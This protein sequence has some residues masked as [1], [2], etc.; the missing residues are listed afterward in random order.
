M[1]VGGLFSGIGGLELGF[2]AAGCETKFVCEVDPC[3]QAVLDD[4]IAPE[5]LV[6]DVADVVSGARELTRGVDLLVAG[7]PCQDLSQVGTT[8]GLR[9]RN[10]GLVR[11]VFQ[12][13]E[14]RRVPWIVLENVPFLLRLSRGAAMHR[15]V[16]EFERLG[17][18]WAYRVLDTRAFGL[19]QRRERVF[20]VASRA[21]HPGRILFN[22]I[23]EGC[24]PARGARATR[25]PA[26]GFY[27]TEGTRGLGWAVDAIPPLKGGSSVGIPSAPAIWI[28]GGGFVTPTI[29]AA[30]R[31]Q[32]FAA[33]WTEPA[34]TLGRSRQRWTLVGNAV[35]VPVSKWLAEQV[36]TTAGALPSKSRPLRRADGWPRAAFGGGR[37]GA[38]VV[39]A[40][41]YPVRMASKSLLRFLGK[42]TLPLSERAARGFLQRLQRSTLRR[43]EEFEHELVHYVSRI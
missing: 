9:G 21:T 19:P 22:D 28:P 7:F 24:P 43:Q 3:A 27:W 29:E 30:E 13:L 35:S 33:G 1:R 39:D 32:G 36:L 25:R 12:I 17:Y 2:E 40:P 11:R 5:T 23:H 20:L 16:S 8:R 15:L 18:R 38:F 10:S 26:C 37:D 6:P 31:L 41:P 34:A 14:Q 42:G 4:R